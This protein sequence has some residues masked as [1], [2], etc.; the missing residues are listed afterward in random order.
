[1]HGLS[2]AIAFDQA[3]IKFAQG[4]TGIFEGYASV[5]NVLD[6]DGD[7]MLPGCFEGALKQRRPGR[8]V[9]MFFNHST[10]DIPIGK[11]LEVR[12][13]A[14]GL[15][16]VG[17]LTPGNTKASEVKA[18]MEHGTISSMSVG[19]SIN[20]ESY[21]K[22]PTGRAFKNLTALR[23][24]SICTMPANEDAQIMAM[25]S[26]DSIQS[27]RDA[28]NWLREVGLS[29]SG[30]QAFIARMKSASL[31]DS[32]ERDELTALVERIRKSPL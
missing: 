6:S 10:Y 14:H 4:K 8:D 7:V 23:E 30:A 26:I 16:A 31:R 9:S 29:K 1:M 21:D 28:E 19:F 11:W 20:G 18:A 12:E 15:Y 5:F 17:E 24:I 3:E 32:D 27:I 13:D 2:K 22:I 25:K